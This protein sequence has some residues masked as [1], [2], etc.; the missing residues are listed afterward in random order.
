L[1]QN[2][3]D[4]S[5]GAVFPVVRSKTQFV[6]NIVIRARLR[7]EKWPSAPKI[8]QLV[9]Q[10][11]VVEDEEFQNNADPIFLRLAAVKKASSKKKRKMKSA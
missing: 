11:G 6:E 9:R 1:S 4:V 2:C 10:T 3:S 8:R 7:S 5:T